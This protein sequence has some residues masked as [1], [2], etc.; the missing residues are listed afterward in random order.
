[1][2]FSLCYGF[3]NILFHFEEVLGKGRKK[4]KFDFKTETSLSYHSN[5]KKY[6]THFLF[7]IFTVTTSIY[8]FTCCSICFV[9]FN[10]IVW[11]EFLSLLRKGFQNF[12]FSKTQKKIKIKRT[13]RKLM[14]MFSIPK[15]ESLFSFS[16]GKV[17]LDTPHTVRITVN[18]FLISF[19]KIT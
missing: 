3:W 14:F 16:V 19:N 2:F 13:N 4:Q 6:K 18:F 15:L 10:D 1:M 17:D 9:D 11:F 12:F 7:R 8:W 5:N